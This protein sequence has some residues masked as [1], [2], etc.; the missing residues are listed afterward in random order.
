MSDQI[1]EARR[2]GGDLTPAMFEIS[3]LL[4]EN[5]H[6]RF[7]TESG[8]SGV[9]WKKSRAALEEGR[10]TLRKKG[11]LQNAVDRNSGANFA[12]VGVQR[13]G[14]QETYAAAHQFGV[15]ETVQVKQHQRTVKQ[16]FGKKLAKAVIANVAAHSRVMRMP[17]RPYLGFD[18]EEREDIV[19]ILEKHLRR[20]FDQAAA[21]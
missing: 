3:G 4:E 9:P 13:G 7:A 1:A 17:A 18:P 2:L 12:E 6:R 10:K 8:P 14:P 21:A 11:Y 15:N 5:V 16:A 20:I 19:I